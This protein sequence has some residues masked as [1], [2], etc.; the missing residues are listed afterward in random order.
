MNLEK[1]LRKYFRRRFRVQRKGEKTMIKKHTLKLVVVLSVLIL[2]L[3][4]GAA[5]AEL[6]TSPMKLTILAGTPGGVWYAMAEGIAGIIRQEIPGANITVAQGS[7]AANI[8]MVQQGKADIGFAYANTIKSAVSGT[9]NFQG[10]ATPDIQI[11]TNVFPSVHQIIFNANS[12]ITDISQFKGRKV[13]I[14][15]NTRASM[16]EVV[17]KNVLQEYG[18]SY[19]DIIKNGGQVLYAASKEQNDGMR[20]GHLDGYFSSGPIPMSQATELMV[21]MKLNV[22]PIRDDI[23]DKL[24]QEL[25]AIKAVIPA[26]TYGN[27]NTIPTISINGMLVVN[28][29]MSPNVAYAIV[30]MLHKNADKLKVIHNFLGGFADIKFMSTTIL[31]IHPGAEKFFQEAK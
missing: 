16:M 27:A 15:V 6:T 19:D 12:G 31:P 28:K 18:I 25:G 17:A 26:G 7:D 5:A 20:G 14:S 11:L 4:G 1:N 13:R 23:R 24:V 22:L 3:A 8:V 9:G 2:L 21:T 29:K 10:K 30:K